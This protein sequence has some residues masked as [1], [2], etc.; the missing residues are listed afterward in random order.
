MKPGKPTTF[1]TCYYKGK[2]KL[3]FCLPGNPVSAIVTFN[4]VVLLSLKKMIGY[5]N[6]KHTEIK[7]V[8]KF[9]ADLDP[10]PEYHRG[11]ITWS[12]PDS[13]ETSSSGYP[14][15]YSTGNQHSSRLLSMNAANCLV[16]LP[17]RTEVKKTVS[18]GE[19]LSALI[20][21]KI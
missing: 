14:S 3:F 16:K 13:N 7:F 4:L 18:S 8:C 1:A 17:A 5:T 9:N 6:T 2:K 11:I 10:R 20:I 12:N 15:V 19:I 21:E